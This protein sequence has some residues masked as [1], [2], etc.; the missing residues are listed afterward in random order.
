MK[1]II[2]DVPDGADTEEILG[3]I[4]TA[5]SAELVQE[6]LPTDLRYRVTWDIVTG[7]G[8]S[9]R[10]QQ[11][12]D[13]DDAE[14]LRTL[15]IAQPN[16]AVPMGE[17]AGKHSD[18]YTDMNEMTVADVAEVAGEAFGPDPIER[19]WDSLADSGY[20]PEGR[21]YTL[22]EMITAYLASFAVEA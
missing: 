12:V 19:M 2:I 4:N 13:A 17:L 21:V 16:Y 1:R 14:A 15:K 9:V 3:L 22:A 10:G 11:W 5:T 7:R 8:S 20:A 6:I 18:V